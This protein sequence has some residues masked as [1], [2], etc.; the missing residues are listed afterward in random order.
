MPE[1]LGNEHPGLVDSDK[2]SEFAARIK[3]FASN[4]RRL[5][6]CLEYQSLQLEA[7]SIQKSE[8]LHRE[9]YSQLMFG[10]ERGGH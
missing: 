2:S 8:Y 7:F 1:V 10:R 5:S 4:T 9:I 6:G 3:S